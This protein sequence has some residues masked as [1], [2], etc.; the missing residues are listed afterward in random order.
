MIQTRPPDGNGNTQQC[1][2]LNSQNIGGNNSQS[3]HQHGNNAHNQG[4]GNGSNQNNMTVPTQGNGYGNKDTTKEEEDSI[5]EKGTDSR[6][7]ME[8]TETKVYLDSRIC[9]N[10]HKCSSF[11]NRYLECNRTH[12]SNKTRT[13]LKQQNVQFPPNQMYPQQNQQQQAIATQ[14][15]QNNSFS[16]QASQPM[17]QQLHAQNPST[18][19]VRTG[20][21]FCDHCGKFGHTISQ[22][23]YKPKP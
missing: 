12:S 6:E 23:W 15:Q 19:A 2:Q 3:Q 14:P 8:D 11:P 20:S 18:S 1:P 5:K 13:I 7:M 17:M 22:C 4:T 9:S 21:K 16:Q 10:P